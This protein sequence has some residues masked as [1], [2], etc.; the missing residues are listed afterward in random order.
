MA[1]IV[2]R[3]EFLTSGGFA[4]DLETAE[5]VDLCYRLGQQGTILY[6]PSMEAVHWG[7]DP[8][9]ATFWSKEVWR[10]KGSLKGIF[11]HGMRWDELPSIGYPDL[12]SMFCATFELELCSR[13]MES[14]I[15][16]NPALPWLADSTGVDTSYRYYAT[17]AEA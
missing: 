7:E 4:E 11:A 17:G 13:P 15:H 3:N 14:T 1:F 5:D 9:L 10:G 2:R 16:L 8:D 12:Y 6:N